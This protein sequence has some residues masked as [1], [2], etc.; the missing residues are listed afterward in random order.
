MVLVDEGMA[1]PAD[2]QVAVGEAG[3]RI[4]DREAGGDAYV[5]EP[6]A[7]ARA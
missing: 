1:P 7:E 5:E 6:V 4:G 3:E 2:D